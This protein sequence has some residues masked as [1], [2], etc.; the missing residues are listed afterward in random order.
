[1]VEISQAEETIVEPSVVSL[2]LLRGLIATTKWA[3]IEGTVAV[4]KITQLLSQKSH[5]LCSSNQEMLMI[6]FK[7]NK[8]NKKS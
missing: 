8:L 2:F 5:I 1:M 3:Q 6:L 4:F 7:N